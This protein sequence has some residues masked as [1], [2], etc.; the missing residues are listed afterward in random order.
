[1]TAVLGLNL[2]HDTSACLI[3]DGTI[4]AA[5]EERWS[6]VKHHR[7]ERSQYL[8]APEQSLQYCFEAA[9]VSAADIEAVWVA[10]MHPNHPLGSWMESGWEAERCHLPG[11]LREQARF[12]SHHTVHILSGYLLS[13]F[14]HAAGLCVDAGGS[15]LGMDMAGREHVSGYYLDRR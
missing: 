2:H 7:H 11:S 15:V 9:G 8:S 3:V 10:A 6:N 1:M 14:D 4:Y 13:P 5:E 12:I